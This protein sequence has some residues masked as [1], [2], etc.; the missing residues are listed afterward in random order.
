MVGEGEDSF[1]EHKLVVMA[2]LDHTY[3]SVGTFRNE[4][5]GP[6]MVAEYEIH[7]DLS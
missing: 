1:A 4:Y 6:F 3:D 2:L 5:W 7:L